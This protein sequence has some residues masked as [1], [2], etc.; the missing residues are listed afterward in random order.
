MQEWKMR[1]M[2][3]WQKMAETESSA[4][5]ISNVETLA[6]LDK[7]THAFDQSDHEG[8]VDPSAEFFFQNSAGFK[9]Y[10]SLFS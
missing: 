8:G 7:F 5:S 6:K 4:K 10:G 1:D 3:M 9:K 2:K